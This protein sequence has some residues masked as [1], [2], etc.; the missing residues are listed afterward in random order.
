MQAIIALLLVGIV[1]FSAS[2][3]LIHTFVS[4]RAPWL[5]Q[6]SA[7]ERT[8]G[9]GLVPTWASGL[10]LLGLMLIGEAAVLILAFWL[11]LVRFGST[12]P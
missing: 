8:A 9:T 10:G 7:W 1:L 6:S 11:G 5:L 4:R 12:P 3:M 2:V